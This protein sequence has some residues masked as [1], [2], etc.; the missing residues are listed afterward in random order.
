MPPLEGQALEEFLDQLL[1]EDIGP[2]DVTSHAVIDADSAISARIAAR[3]R[4]VAAGLEL[5]AAVFKRLDPATQLE[6]LAKDGETLSSDSIL[7]E[8]AG[9]AHT[10]LAGERAAL[11]VLQ[12][13]SGIAT[14]T[15][16]YV[17]AIEGTGAVLLD[18]RKTSPLLRRL[19]K[20]ATR[21]GGARNHRMGLYDAI[22]IK[23]NHI[24]AA[25]DVATAVRR[26]VEE[27]GKTGLTVEVEC[28]SLEQA[29]AAVEAGAARLLL[30][31]M[32]PEALAEAVDRFKGRAKLEASGRITLE[33]IR[34]VAETG[35]DYISVGRITQSAPAVD[36]GLD[37]TVD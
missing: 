33:N 17:E 9:D 37:V 10:I 27:A 16:A 21:M 7:M 22:L 28:D 23:D 30:D 8:I 20:Y 5:A 2:G 35:I 14:L 32:R 13:L 25:G 12:H 3:E 11:N 31:N 34:Q 29:E 26:A 15:R 36:I 18:T 24:A 1:A 4:I 6:M 19:E